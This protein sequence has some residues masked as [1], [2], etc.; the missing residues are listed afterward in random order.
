MS[1]WETQSASKTARQPHQALLGEESSPFKSYVDAAPM[2]G[3]GASSAPFGGG[4]R[5]G[6]GLRHLYARVTGQA[7]GTAA[8]AGGRHARA[9]EGMATAAWSSPP[10]PDGDG[11]GA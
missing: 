6:G 2:L 9:Q 4:V 5:G 10:S 1:G 7:H 8:A 11:A 3:G